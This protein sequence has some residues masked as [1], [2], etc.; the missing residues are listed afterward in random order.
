MN[1]DFAASRLT[2]SMQARCA[3]SNPS[4]LWPMV[5]LLQEVVR[6]G[7]R[8]LFWRDLGAAPK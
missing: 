4:G 1:E 2:A 8:Q 6:A 3:I 7:D 5:I